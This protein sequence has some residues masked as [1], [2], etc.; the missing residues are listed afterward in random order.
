MT[1]TTRNS[2][3]ANRNHNLRDAR[4]TEKEKHI[5]P[6]G[7]HETWL[8]V[9][10]REAYEKLFGPAV[11]QYNQSQK[12][13]DRQISDYYRKICNDK[14][15]HAVYEMIIGIYPSSGE[16]L[17]QKD[18][19]A[20]LLEFCKDWR[21]SNPNLKMIGCYYH[22]D[23]EGQPHVHIDYVPVA[24][25]SKGLKK[26]NGLNRALEQQGFKSKAKTKTAQILWEARENKRLED[27]CRA[28][29]YRVMHPQK[30][31]GA[32]HLSVAAYKEKKKLEKLQKKSKKIADQL[33]Q[34]IEEAQKDAVDL[35][36]YDDQLAIKEFDRAVRLCDIRN[37]LED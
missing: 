4:C 26:R 16:Q 27:I 37:R 35:G 5:D 17:S 19:R 30:G 22:A 31:K 33:D 9:E 15:K 10:P 25:Y 14:Q 29:G 1:I 36:R 32:E 11:D 3:A 7:R 2:S 28:R 8:D 20:M 12:R 23:E 18:Q 24:E 13:A 34:A 6:K 21:K